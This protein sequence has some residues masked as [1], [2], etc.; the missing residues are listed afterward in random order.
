MHVHPASSNVF[1][2]KS[3]LSG[4]AKFRLLPPGGSPL[5]PATCLRACFSTHEAG[6]RPLFGLGAG[7][8]PARDSEWRVGTSGDGRGASGRGRAADGSDYPQQVPNRF[9]AKP[10]FQHLVRFQCSGQALLEVP[11]ALFSIA[12]LRVVHLS[13]NDIRFLSPRIAQWSALEELELS[14]NQIRFFPFAL[15][16]AQCQNIKSLKLEDNPGLDRCVMDRHADWNMKRFLVMGSESMA[17]HEAG[18]QFLMCRYFGGSESTLN[19][20]PKDV[21]K[22]IYTHLHLL[23]PR[24]CDMCMELASVICHA[25]KTTMLCRSP[26]C[27]ELHKSQC[28][29]KYA[30]MV[31]DL[32]SH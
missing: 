30:A 29:K 22:L 2:K 12:T 4:G 8:D 23:S 32:L 6:S 20:V 16:Q 17:G 9:L 15:V 10:T 3:K 1:A 5:L 13:R 24:M 31:Q 11:E 26:P 19:S 27:L 28:D 18:I 21:V 14:C 7:G 25:C